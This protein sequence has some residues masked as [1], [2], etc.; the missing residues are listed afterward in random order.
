MMMFEGI[1][2]LAVLAAA[3]SAFLLGGVWYGPL[4]KNAWCR[5][6]GMD[7]NCPPE[8]H[9]GKV[10]GT[11]FLAALVAAAAFGVF[12]RP[13]P[14]LFIA[15]HAG[16]L[17]GAAYVATSFGINYAFA[18]RSFKLWLIDG[19]YHVLQFT[20]YGLVLGLWH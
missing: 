4:F 14:P 16:F 18:G 10:F 19:G 2:W 7:P 11:A 8:G 15:L 12:L 13:D 20:L 1:N 9:P 3:V 17:V 6:N 5:E